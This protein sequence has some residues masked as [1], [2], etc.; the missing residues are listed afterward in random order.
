MSEKE[1]SVLVRKYEQ[2]IESG[3]PIYLDAD[4]FGEL[5]EYYDSLDEPDTA[6]EI[7]EA[8]LA[9]HP[10]SSSLLIKKAK[11]AVY[12]GEY[13]QALEILDKSLS[14]YDFD[15]YLLRIECYLQLELYA[16]AYA[17]TSEMLEKEENEAP[18]TVFSELGF[19]YVEADCFREAVTYFLKSLKYN[20]EN[21]DVLSDLAYA[22]E[23]LD[24]FESAIEVTNKILDIEPYTY[25]AW[26]NMGKLYSLNEELEKAIDA[27][28]FALTINDSDN[29]VLKLKAH[30]L[31]LSG[32]AEEAIEIFDS[33]LKSDPDDVSIYFLLAE[34]YQSLELF[35]EALHILS[36]YEKIKGETVES[37]SRKAY[38]FFQQGEYNKAAYI[39][40]KGLVSY[41]D[42][43]DLRMLAGE[44][45]FKEDRLEEAKEFYLSIYSEDNDNFHLVDR[46]ALVSIKE[47]D[48]EKAAYYTEKLLNMD[49]SNAAV[50][51]RL[52]LLYF[53]LDDKE[54][55]NEILDQFTDKELL[56]LFQ[57]IYIPQNPGYFDR[58]TLIVYLNRARET[59]TLFKNLEY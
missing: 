3:K 29:N 10:T 26:V 27:F 32:R 35:D 49:V 50:K 8:G 54:H 33:L 55:F 53:E 18:E 15:L 58:D 41:P 34:C 22:Y 56:S 5:A 11:F 4:E 20:P 57:L 52:A 13:S 43:L 25:E 36:Y 59:R 12:D 45:A 6:R 7:V 30:C 9:I 2:S 40:R 14:E 47:E 24:N 17:L 21:M 38:V 1:I 44:I 51:E 46:L 37:L 16:E 48:Y 42:F 31:S 39:V 28:D 23:M 19:V